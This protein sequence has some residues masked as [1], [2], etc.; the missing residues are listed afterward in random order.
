MRKK[1]I[2]SNIVLL[3]L[4]SLFVDMSTEMVYPL[5][6]IYL[7]TILGATPAIVSGILGIVCAAAIAF[8]LRE[9]HLAKVGPKQV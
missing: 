4:V 3:G 6:P 7:T 9:N 1:M 2:V 5:I 8:I